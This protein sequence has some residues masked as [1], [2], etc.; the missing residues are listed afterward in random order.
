MLCAKCL[1]DKKR[2]DF[3]PGQYRLRGWKICKRCAADYQNDWR[4]NNPERS[5]D[6]KRKYLLRNPKRSMAYQAK[7]RSTTQE[8]P[9]NITEHDFEI[10]EYCPVLD[11]ELNPSSGRATD[12][13]PS[14]DRII[15]ELGYVP[16]NIR[17]VSWRAN[18]IKADGTAEEHDRIAA[19]IRK[20]V[21]T[22]SVLCGIRREVK[23]NIER[24][25]GR[26]KSAA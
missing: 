5:W 12:S 8:V 1:K 18:R 17:V 3:S 16:K 21:L 22:N 23:P 13:S 7:L 25:L 26:I 2:I 11:I 14:L 20:K 4:A 9:F 10:P 24:V 6:T 15:P 19:Y